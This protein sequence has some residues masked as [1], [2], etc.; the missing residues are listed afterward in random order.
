MPIIELDDTRK[1]IN[2]D[3]DNERLKLN[4]PNKSYKNAWR[5]I[6]SFMTTSHFVHRQYSGY[7]S[8][9][10]ISYVEVVHVISEMTQALPWLKYCV[11]QFDVTAVF[12]QYSLLDIIGCSLF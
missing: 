10:N 7:V 12:D 11:R 2:F 3:L 1:A 8:E 9:K 4:Y 5:D 6:H